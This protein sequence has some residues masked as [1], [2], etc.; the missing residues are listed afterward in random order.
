MFTIKDLADGKCAV[1]NDGTVEELNKV[2]EMTFPKDIT[3]IKDLCKYYR[4]NYTNNSMWLGLNGVNLPTQS[5]KK[6]LLD[7]F[8]LPKNWYVKATIEN[9]DILQKWRG[10]TYID[11]RNNLVMLSIKVWSDTDMDSIT[12][13]EYTEITF[14]QFKKYVLKQE[15]ID[16]R[17]P[18]ILSPEN[19]ENII[20]AVCAVWKTK[21]AKLWAVN[22][23]LKQYNVIDEEFYKEMRK[24]CTQD[25][26]KLF[27]EIFGKDI[28]EYK[29]TNGEL[30]WVKTT[31]NNPWDLRY[32]TGKLNGF[33]LECYE[34]QEKSGE[35]H[36]WNIHQPAP[37]VK[38]P[39]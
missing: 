35:I 32:T 23:I 4:M 39:D 14:G 30:V 25:Q 11:W 16:N 22:I 12:T 6:F 37:G 36:S 19:A 2:L 7:D 38:L 31:V 28:P 5:V 1:I 29:Y 15:S 27:D 13:G 21:L 26:Y 3:N 20:K 8:V 10:G 24:A 9:R 17:F 18:F 34:L 33:K